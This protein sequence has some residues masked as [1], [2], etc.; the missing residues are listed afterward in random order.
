MP[1]TAPASP[2]CPVQWPVSKSPYPSSMLQPLIQTFPNEYAW[3]GIRPAI[4]ADNGRRSRP[5]GKALSPRDQC[6]P[7]SSVEAV[8]TKSPPN[9]RGTPENGPRFVGSPLKNIGS[10]ALVKIVSCDGLRPEGGW[11]CPDKIVIP[12]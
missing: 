6:K 2:N 9:H 7:R 8:C 3:T 5:G 1:N 11:P 10:I 12:R 4:H